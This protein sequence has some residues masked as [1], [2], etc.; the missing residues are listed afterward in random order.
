MLKVKIIP[1]TLLEQNCS[2]VWCD[3]TMKAAVIDPGGDVDRIIAAIDKY[4]VAVEKILI[5]HG[6]LDHAGGAAEL[7]ERLGVPIIGPGKQDKFW[8]EQIP[9]NCRAYGLPEGR[10]FTPDQWLEEGDKISFGTIT[11][12][13]YSCPGHTP[14]H[15]IFHEKKAGFAFV[16]DVLFQGSIGRTDFPRSDHN[17]LIKSIREKLWS[18]GDNTRF[19]SGHGPMSSFGAERKTNPFVGDRV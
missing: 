13:V 3:Q 12:D 17:T 19:I 6:H 18:L 1:V 8:I 7:S 16:G 4:G 10:T 2:L 14:G 15:V 11:M 5:T 9:E